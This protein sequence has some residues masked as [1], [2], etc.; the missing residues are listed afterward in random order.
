MASDVRGAPGS[1]R[2][3]RPATVA[4]TNTTIQNS[5]VVPSPPLL[6]K[7]YPQQDILRLVEYNAS[8]RSGPKQWSKRGSYIIGEKWYCLTGKAQHSRNTH[9]MQSS[10]QNLEIR[11]TLFKVKSDV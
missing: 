10:T 8:T 5:L 7:P 3:P 6:S 2:Q 9:Q 4:A 11:V 1:L